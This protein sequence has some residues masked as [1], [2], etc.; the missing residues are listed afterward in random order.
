MKFLSFNKLMTDRKTYIDR[1]PDRH[2]HIEY[3]RT[4]KSNSNTDLQTDSQPDKQ[5]K[6]GKERQ[7]DIQKDI[8]TDKQTEKHSY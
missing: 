2:T 6:E 7:I 3:I 4:D 8:Q 1:Q 5:I